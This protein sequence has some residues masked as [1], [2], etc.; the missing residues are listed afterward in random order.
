[1]YYN[2]GIRMLIEY[3]HPVTDCEPSGVA[4]HFV[5]ADRGRAALWV[6]D[7]PVVLTEAGAKFDPWVQSSYTP[8]ITA[9]LD[10]IRRRIEP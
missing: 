10:S 3:T 5:L 8:S 4:V 6:F 2:C 7:C 9:T 1:M